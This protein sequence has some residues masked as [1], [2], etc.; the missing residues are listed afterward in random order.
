MKK[1]TIATC[2]AYFTYSA[3]TSPRDIVESIKASPGDTNEILKPLVKKI[4]RFADSNIKEAI[5]SRDL[6]DTRPAIFA[7]Y[8]AQHNVYINP[9]D[10]ESY[11]ALEGTSDA[12]TIVM[13]S[14][15]HAVDDF[16]SIKQAIEL[17]TVPV[18]A[19]H[20][21]YKDAPHAFMQR[22]NLIV[23][24]I[25]VDFPPDH[26]IWWQPIT[27]VYTREAADFIEKLRLAKL[28]ALTD[29]RFFNLG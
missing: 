24:G 19:L 9:H 4:Q 10:I 18:G 6:G 25:G 29:V 1:L 28:N 7:N 23:K 8:M 5:D 2:L 14:L 13:I 16:S 3:T 26:E 12:F 15:L 27:C 21:K 22:N 11:C 17:A 20:T